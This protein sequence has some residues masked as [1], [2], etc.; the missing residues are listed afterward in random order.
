LLRLAVL[1][2]AQL[3]CVGGHIP[4]SMFQFTN[5]VPY[6]PPGTGGWKVAQVVVLMGRISTVFPLNA[7]CEVEVGVPEK[8]VNG[9]V[10]DEI[11]QTAAAKAA[12]EAA[13][14][15]LREHLPTA[16]ACARF[17]KHM[18]G[19]LGDKNFGTVP[20]ARVTEFRTSGVPK[21]TFP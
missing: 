17:R 5:V 14:I 18:E 11:A 20:G 4:P 1:G 3:A 10:L 8:N 13:R 15:V 9:W 6:T 7:V 2:A 19:I 21:T 12:D 16:L